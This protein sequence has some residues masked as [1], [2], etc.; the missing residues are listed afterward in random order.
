[1]RDALIAELKEELK[2]LSLQAEQLR[3]QHEAVERKVAA[4]TAILVAYGAKEAPVRERLRER[5]RPPSRVFDHA[6][7]LNLE[8]LS[9]AV[10]PVLEAV[11]RLLTGA[12]EPIRTADIFAALESRGI[13]LM[14][15]NPQNTLSARLSN[16]PRF[17]SHGRRG[18]TLVGDV[19]EAADEDE[20]SAASDREGSA[21]PLNSNAQ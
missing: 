20:S 1:M 3:K 17:K 11:V 4:V 18:W 10:D 12:A 14:G 6:G 13:K 15:K 21:K 2:T 7:R 9:K 5:Q 19:L 8:Q 16:S